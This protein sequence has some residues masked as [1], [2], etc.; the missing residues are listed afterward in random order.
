MPPPLR[1]GLGELAITATLFSI[2]AS[3]RGTARTL[4]AVQSVIGRR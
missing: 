3:A 2:Y 1:P 4:A